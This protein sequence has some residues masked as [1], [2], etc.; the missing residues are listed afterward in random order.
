[1]IKN[2]RIK[3]IFSFIIRFVEIKDL[4]IYFHENSLKKHYFF[5]N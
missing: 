2:V 5:A 1:M 4:F 3:N